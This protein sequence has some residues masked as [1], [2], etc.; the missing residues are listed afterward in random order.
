MTTPRYCECPAP[1]I[2]TNAENVRFCEDCGERENPLVVPL[3]Q[4]L[5]G[6]LAELRADFRALLRGAAP[7][8]FG[9]TWVD[10]ATE[11]RRIG[12]SEDWLRRNA[13]RL[14]GRQAKARGRWMFNPPATDARLAAL[15]GA[16][17]EPPSHAVTPRALPGNAERLPVR[18]RAA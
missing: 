10:L 2:A 16:R 12:R 15:E 9:A 8:E 13:R 11:A 7:P 3:A 6:P 4:A 17:L 18:D 14:G 5:A 1:T